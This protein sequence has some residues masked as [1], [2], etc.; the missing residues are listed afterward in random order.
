[1]ICVNAY[2]LSKNISEEDT[3]YDDSGINGEES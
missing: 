1:M 2:I 3:D